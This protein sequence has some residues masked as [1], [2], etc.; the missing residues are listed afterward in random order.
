MLFGEELGGA[1]LLEYAD[2]LPSL[3]PPIPSQTRVRCL[4]PLTHPTS[5]PPPPASP[6]VPSFNDAHLRPSPLTGTSTPSTR[7]PD[8]PRRRPPSR[9]CSPARRDLPLISPDLPLPPPGVTRVV[10]PAFHPNASPSPFHSPHSQPQPTP[11][12]R[13][14]DARHVGR[15][16]AAAPS[17]SAPAS[18]LPRRSA[19]C[20][21][22]PPL[23]GLQ[24]KKAPP[25]APEDITPAARLVAPKGSGRACAPRSAA[26]AAW[27]LAAAPTAR[28]RHLQS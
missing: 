2:Y 11:P 19:C 9:A 8:P 1:A 27:R 12:P 13:A 17:C 22:S 6:P 23:R 18:I 21:R 7:A 5:S 3:T 14:S 15:R 25:A 16:R 10:A 28:L 24:K 20:A 26:S 4:P